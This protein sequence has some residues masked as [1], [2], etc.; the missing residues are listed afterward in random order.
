MTWNDDPDLWLVDKSSM[1]IYVYIYVYV[2]LAIYVD[3]ILIWSKDPMAAIN[4]MEKAYM[5]KG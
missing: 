3:E 2:Y 4:S 1:Y 5:L